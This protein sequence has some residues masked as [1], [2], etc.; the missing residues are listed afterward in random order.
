MHDL[1]W[2]KVV[3]VPY[4]LDVYVHSC[5][6][7]HLC[8]D[9]CD[10][11][12]VLDVRNVYNAIDINDVY[13]VQGINYLRVIYDVLYIEINI[14]PHCATA[15]IVDSAQWATA[16]NQNVHRR[17]QQSITDHNTCFVLFKDRSDKKKITLFLLGLFDDNKSRVSNQFTT[18]KLLNERS[19]HFSFHRHWFCSVTLG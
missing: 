7:S 19:R 14:I 11:S 15:K 12:S 16:Q 9:V 8:E 13:N 1:R 18:T 4:F 2:R 3:D 10:A 5:R 17:Q 6:W